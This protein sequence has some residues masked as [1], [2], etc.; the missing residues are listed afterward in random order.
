MSLLLSAESTPEG[1]PLTHPPPPRAAAQRPA[2]LRRSL[3]HASAAAGAMRGRVGGDRGVQDLCM[4]LRRGVEWWALWGPSHRVAGAVDVCVV[5]C[6]VLCVCGVG[7][8]QD[9]HGQST[10]KVHHRQRRL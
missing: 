7:V 1:R 9:H 5:L 4:A 10:V 3:R 6:C 8:E 2:A